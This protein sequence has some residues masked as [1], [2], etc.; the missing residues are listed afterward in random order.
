MHQALSAAPLLPSPAPRRLRTRPL[1]AGSGSALV[2][3]SS[4]R[5]ARG[6]GLEVP[7]GRAADRGVRPSAGTAASFRG[8]TSVSCGLHF[9]FSF[10]AFN[11][12]PILCLRALLPCSI[13]SL[14]SIA[15]NRSVSLLI[16][17]VKLKG[18]WAAEEG[19]RGR[20]I[21]FLPC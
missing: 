8:P 20:R 9:S 7:R 3:A 21:V 6:C 10:L 19:R 14:S 4:A 12:G 17:K 16:A 13:T 15:S 11:L 2:R 18:G 1:A 5:P